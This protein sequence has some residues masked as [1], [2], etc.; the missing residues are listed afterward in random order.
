MKK[1]SAD[2]NYVAILRSWMESKKLIMQD[3]EDSIVE[4]QRT[5]KKTEAMIVLEK[6]QLSLHRQD[7][8]ETEKSLAEWI[9]THKKTKE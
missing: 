8:K 4:H 2:A 1:Y 5:K 7:L 3:C 9:R 6:K